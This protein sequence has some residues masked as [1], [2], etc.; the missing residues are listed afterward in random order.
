MTN[1]KKVL[2]L[3]I[4]S[5][6]LWSCNNPSEE[7]ATHQETEVHET[8]QHDMNEE[9]LKLNN[10]EKWIV[11]DEMKLHVQ[12]GSMLVNNY[13]QEKQTDYKELAQQLKEENN[14]IVKTC[15]MKGESH[16]ELHKWL[17]P[18]M[19]LVKALENETDDSKAAEI[20][21]DIQHSYQQYFLYFI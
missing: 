12:N 13:I 20:V 16:D 8:H 18:H 11:N 17:H 1:L 2:V 6:F 10:G 7:T 4:G 19:E 15:T 3:G 14:N 5:F 21:Q 9:P